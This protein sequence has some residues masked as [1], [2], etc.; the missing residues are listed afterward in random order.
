MNILL[1]QVYALL[2]TLAVT[3]YGLPWFCL[4]LVPLAVL[5]YYIQRFYRRTSRFILQSSACVYT[6][7][8]AILWWVPHVMRVYQVVCIEYTDNILECV[9]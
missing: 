4:L 9:K 5:Y 6:V 2:G 7:W 8:L 3:C 1:A